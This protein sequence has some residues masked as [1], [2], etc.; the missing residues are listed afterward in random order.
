MVEYRD[1]I[2]QDH[3]K[4]TSLPK[5]KPFKMLAFLWPNPLQTVDLIGKR[6][7]ALLFQ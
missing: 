6:E 4:T 5:D 7:T 2:Q 1:V 3:A